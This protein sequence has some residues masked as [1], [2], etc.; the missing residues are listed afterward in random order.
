MI[1]QL[2]NQEKD[3]GECRRSKERAIKKESMRS[4]VIQ[5]H[6]LRIEIGGET[7]KFTLP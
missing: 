6:F 5:Y 1:S 2:A 4:E 7:S 3:Q